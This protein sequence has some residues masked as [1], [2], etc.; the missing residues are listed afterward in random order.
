MGAGPALQAIDMGGGCGG[1]LAYLHARAPGMLQQLALGDSS[2][3]ALT[4]AGPVV[5]GIA[6]R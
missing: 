3:R 2:L 4:L 5:G 6:A 1:W